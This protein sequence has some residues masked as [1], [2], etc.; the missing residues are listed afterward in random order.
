MNVSIPTTGISASFSTLS[1]A[2]HDIAN[3]NTPGYKQSIPHQSELKGGGTSL[4]SLSQNN[5]STTADSDTD[6]ATEMTE[7]KNSEYSVKANSAVIKVQN[8]MMG[9][10]LDIFA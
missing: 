3:V 6:I 2:A 4:L 10:L 7:L 8:R 5:A 1:V 9:A